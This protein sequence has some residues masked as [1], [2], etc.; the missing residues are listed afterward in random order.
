[1]ITLFKVKVQFYPYILYKD[2]PVNKLPEV[3]FHKN[4]FLNEIITSL[5]PSVE[6]NLHNYTQ[7]KISLFVFFPIDCLGLLNT[8]IAEW[9]IRFLLAGQ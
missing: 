3:V 4:I 7:Q 6:V 1:M 8:V 2:K 5:A 9:K